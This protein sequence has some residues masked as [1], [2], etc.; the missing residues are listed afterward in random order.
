MIYQWMEKAQVSS[1]MK[2]LTQKN[3]QPHLLLVLVIDPLEIG[4]LDK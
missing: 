2:S 3:L 1:I 4:W